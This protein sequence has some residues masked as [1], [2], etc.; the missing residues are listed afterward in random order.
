VRSKFGVTIVGVK[1]KGE[2]FTH[3]TPETVVEDGDL[4]IV[5]GPEDNVEGFSELT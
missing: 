1:R 4:I 5:S 2:D 3:A